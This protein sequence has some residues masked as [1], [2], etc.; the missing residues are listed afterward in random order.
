MLG[1][2]YLF[3]TPSKTDGKVPSQQGAPITCNLCCWEVSLQT[4]VQTLKASLGVV[5]GQNLDLQLGAGGWALTDSAPKKSIK[6]LKQC[7]FFAKKVLK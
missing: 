2:I 7:L 1:K 3:L 5:I 6:C 4:Y